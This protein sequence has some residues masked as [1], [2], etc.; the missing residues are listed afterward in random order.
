MKLFIGELSEEDKKKIQELKKLLD[1]E[2]DEEQLEHVQKWLISSP[3][4]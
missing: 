1:K 4:S 2:K 3:S